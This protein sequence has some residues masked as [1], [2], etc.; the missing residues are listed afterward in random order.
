MGGNK[1]ISNKLKLPTGDGRPCRGFSPS[2]AERDDGVVSKL[3][4]PLC[5][6]FSNTWRTLDLGGFIE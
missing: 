3:H 4:G 5:V 2:E 6:N 1:D